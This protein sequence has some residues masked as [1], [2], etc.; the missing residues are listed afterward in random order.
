ML[1][2]YDLL[3]LRKKGFSSDYYTSLAALNMGGGRNRKI[4]GI[5]PLTIKSNGAPVSEWQ[6]WGNT[7]QNTVPFADEPVEVLGVGNK[8]INRYNWKDTSNR[9]NLWHNNGRYSY[10][11]TRLLV[12]IPCVGDEMYTLYRFDNVS[13]PWYTSQC[14]ERPENNV[15][16]LRNGQTTF[17]NIGNEKNYTFRTYPEMNYISISFTGLS[18]EQIIE[19]ILPKLMVCRSSSTTLPYEPYGYKVP[20][21]VNQSEDAVIYL[22]E[23][24]YKGDYL[25]LGSDGNGI[26]HR[27]NGIKIF[28][29]SENWSAVNISG[30]GAGLQITEMKNGEYQA[31]FCSHAVHAE[32]T[33]AGRMAFG[34]N[35]NSL[36]WFGIL[37]L[38]ELDSISEFKSFLSEQKASDTP[39]T[40]CFP[41]ASPSDTPVVLP[42]I[43]TVSGINTINVNTEITP[44]KMY[45]KYKG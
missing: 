31:G 37:D 33:A 32:D 40:V 26:L 45:V 38:L 30:N 43:N 1:S 13:T 22:D 24:L 5:P 11:E 36:Y 41:L 16:Y 12:F 6:L 35:D 27:E 42:Q 28:D 19:Q 29:G 2:Y 39:L 20:I 14:T 9:R 34:M 25:K 7:S 18:N 15:S 44:E 4:S 17:V 8:T 23:P 21:T 3:K 10:D